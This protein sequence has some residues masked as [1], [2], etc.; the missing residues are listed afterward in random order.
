MLLFSSNNRA[1]AFTSPYIVIEGTY[2]VREETGFETTADLDKD[3]LRIAV[4]QNAAY[5][6]FLSLALKQATIVRAQTP[7]AALEMFAGEGLDAAAGVRQALDAFAAARTGF[8]V[9]PDGF[10]VIQQALATPR[11]REEVGRYLDAYI[12]DL[13]SSGWLRAALDRNG[14]ASVP[15][16][17][18]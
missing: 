13:K 9:L 7:T 4:G 15:L 3:G 16:A 8:R 6:L 14:Q 11:G 10:M 17:A 2:L 12:A 5:D 18:P 1:R